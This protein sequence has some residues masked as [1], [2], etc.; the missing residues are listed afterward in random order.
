MCGLIKISIKI[1]HFTQNHCCIDCLKFKMADHRT[2]KGIYE[3]IHP[4][5]THSSKVGFQSHS[6]FKRHAAEESGKW[7]KM[8]LEF[9]DFE[10]K[11]HLQKQH[12]THE[13]D[14]MKSGSEWQ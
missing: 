13:S 6:E 10:T 3:Y 2:N 5:I 11:G 8:K 14:L 7:R 4:F 9:C 12:F 1:L